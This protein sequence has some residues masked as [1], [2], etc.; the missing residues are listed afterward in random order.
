MPPKGSA[1]FNIGTIE[2]WPVMPVTLELGNCCE[3]RQWC[4]SPLYGHDPIHQNNLGRLFRYCAKPLAPSDASVLRRNL[5]ARRTRGIVM[6]NAASS[7]ITN[8]RGTEPSTP[9]M[10][11]RHSNGLSGSK[12]LA[13]R[14]RLPAPTLL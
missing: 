10:P 6:R 2:G 12:L 4:P 9:H 1:A 14:V 11:D 8:I 7:S 5:S 13:T 3:A